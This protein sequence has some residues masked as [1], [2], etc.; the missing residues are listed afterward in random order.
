MEEERNR[1][2][3]GLFALF[4]T[5]HDPQRACIIIAENFRIPVEEIRVLLAKEIAECAPVKS[6]GIVKKKKPGR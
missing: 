3:R 4:R 2:I 6:L 5:T 1:N